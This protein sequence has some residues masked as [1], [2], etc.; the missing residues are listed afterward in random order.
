MT[1]PRAALAL[2]A[3]ATLGA[4]P[5]PAAALAASAGIAARA[6]SMARAAA[7][8][9][10]GQAPG[11]TP[12]GMA[13]AAGLYLRVFLL[14]FGPGDAVWERFG[15][16]AIWIHDEAKGTDV[17][18]NYGMFDFK[19]P[20]FLPN[21]VLGR[22]E[23]WMEGFDANAMIRAYAAQNR[24]VWAQELDLTPRQRVELQSFLEWNARPENRFYRYD[25]YRDNCTTRVRDAID[26]VTGGALRAQTADRRARMTYRDHTRMLTEA[27]PLVYTGTELGLGEAVDRPIS[28]WDEM[29]LPLQLMEHLRDIDLTGPDGTTRPLVVRETTLFDASRP[30]VPRRP[31]RWWPFYLVLGVAVGFLLYRGAAG[32]ERSRRRRLLFGALGA[33]WSMLIGF[34]GLLLLFLWGFTDHWAAHHNENV[35]QFDPL[36]LALVVLLPAYA[37]GRMRR[38]TRVL[39]AAIAAL[40]V[41]GFVLQALPGLDQTNGEII[42]LALPAHVGLALGLWRGG[43]RSRVAP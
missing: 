36:A 29:F 25:Y 39:A 14:T 33:T 43:G 16:D 20:H 26:V 3:L 35:L 15:H 24:S 8:A 9:R 34:F 31:P 18:Y 12:A 11:R 41:L 32:I 7:S 4:L 19:A 21:F 2:A 10:P 6:G 17:A 42:A 22:M 5:Q 40:A 38:A 37:W 23:Y 30:P 13:D 1:R 28:V 27:A